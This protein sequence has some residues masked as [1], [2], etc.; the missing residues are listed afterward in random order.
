[1]K[2]ALLTIIATLFF[3]APS[4]AVENIEMLVNSEYL[5]FANARIQSIKSNNPEIISAQRVASINPDEQQIL[6][7]TKKTGIAK[8]QIDTDKGLLNYFIEIKTDKV[9]TNDKFIKLDEPRL[10]TN[11]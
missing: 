2:K 6:F 4:F 11:D 8:V 5:Y 9:Q 7:T 3:I 1:M 10:K